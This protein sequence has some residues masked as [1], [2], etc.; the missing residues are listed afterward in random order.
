MPCVHALDVL[1]SPAMTMT[2]RTLR[3]ILL[4]LAIVL[5]AAACGNGDDDAPAASGDAIEGDA[6]T[7]GDEAAGEDGSDDDAASGD[8]AASGDFCGA[9][10]AFHG[11][12]FETQLEDDASAEDV[13]AAHE[14]LDPLWSDVEA[15]A[16][17]ELA[18]P[19]EELGAS[20]DALGEGDPEP[21]NADETATTYFAMV[22]EALD[23]CVEEVIDV[24]GVD[25][26]FTGIPETIPSGP[27]GLRLEN[28]T[29]ADEE[30]E[31]IIFKK[32]DGD[33]RTAQEILNDPAAQE[34]GPGEFAGAIFASPGTTSGTFLDLAPGDYIG[35]C[36]VPMGS[37][38]E[39]SGEA[40]DA[41]EDGGEDQATD[42]DAA[43]EGEESGGPPHFTQGMV[44]EFSVE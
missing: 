2:T 44:V 21:F 13:E 12:I 26:A 3:P 16:P 8:Q 37:G 11:A 41:V 19:V 27:I 17:E 36:F 5:V 4:F 23:E 18:D 33:T 6:S 25:Y 31:L 22:S 14:T 30:H 39:A 38:D 7:E 29:E 24:T 32:A 15:S 43:A 9:L 40:D 1:H 35:V 20:I 34:Q 10:Q 28:G 42:D